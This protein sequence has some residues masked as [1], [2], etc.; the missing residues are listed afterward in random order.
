MA[1]H[2]ANI[3]VVAGCTYMMRWGCLPGTS[4][5]SCVLDLFGFMSVVQYNIVLWWYADRVA[6]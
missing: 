5:R 1:C 4:I 3:D 6:T 2:T